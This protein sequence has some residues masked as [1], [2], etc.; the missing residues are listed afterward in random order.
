MVDYHSNGMCIDD[1]NTKTGDYCGEWV[2][3]TIVRLPMWG[4]D[5]DNEIDF[6]WPAQETWATMS[7]ET[8]LKSIEFNSKYDILHLVKVNLSND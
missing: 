7:P 3:A 2:G 4:N 6:E 1:Y 5:G 8:Y